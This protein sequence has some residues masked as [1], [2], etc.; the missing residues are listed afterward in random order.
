VTRELGIKYAKLES[1]VKMVFTNV[2][3]LDRDAS[4]TNDQNAAQ[5]LGERVVAVVLSVR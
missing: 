1:P 5:A 3:V 4:Q 2:S